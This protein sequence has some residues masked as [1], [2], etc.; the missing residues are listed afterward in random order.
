MSKYR[1]LIS[2]YDAQEF[3]IEA[4]NAADAEDEAFRRMEDGCTLE[5]SLESITKLRD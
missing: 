2:V 1:V 5:Y 4:E 3:E